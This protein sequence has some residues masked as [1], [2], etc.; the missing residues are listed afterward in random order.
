MG[1]VGLMYRLPLVHDRR[2]DRRT[3]VA[4]MEI[5]EVDLAQIA[6]ALAACAVDPPPFLGA[7]HD[8]QHFA[9]LAARFRRVRDELRTAE[10]NGA[11][12]A[13]TGP[14]PTQEVSTP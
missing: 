12:P 6:T 1:L 5:T 3:P 9:Q 11:A 4:S 2:L 8:R 7:D 10:R 14:R 13:D